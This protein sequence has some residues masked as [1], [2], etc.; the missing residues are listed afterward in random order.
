METPVWETSAG[1]CYKNILMLSQLKQAEMTEH[2]GVAGEEEGSVGGPTHA[3]QAAET[4]VEA[5][6][7]KLTV[8]LEATVTLTETL[9]FLLTSPLLQW[10]LWVK[11]ISSNSSPLGE[12][13]KDGTAHNWTNSQLAKNQTK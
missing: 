7:A 3:L 8:S 12:V 5:A 11:K 2:R 13:I 10:G 9:S 6:S 4:V 1:R